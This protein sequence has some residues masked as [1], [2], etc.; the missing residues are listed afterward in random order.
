MIV[1]YPTI[2]GTLVLCLIGCCLAALIGRWSRHSQMPRW[3]RASIA[4]VVLSWSTLVVGGHGGA[5]GVAIPSALLFILSTRSKEVPKPEEI[6]VMAIMVACFAAVFASFWFF[7][8]RPT[9]GK[10]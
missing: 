6:M 4:T 8:R 1:A 9:G 3:L 5:G 7:S 2:I 10:P